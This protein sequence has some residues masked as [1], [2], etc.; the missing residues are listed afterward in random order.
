[1]QRF[2]PLAMISYT[3]YYGRKLYE[4]LTEMRVFTSTVELMKSRNEY[5]SVVVRKRTE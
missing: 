2:N 3:Y 1:M 5:N 4:V